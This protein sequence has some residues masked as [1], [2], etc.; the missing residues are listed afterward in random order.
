MSL[1]IVIINP[2]S[3]GGATRD[4]WPEIASDLATPL[5]ALRSVFTDGAGQGIELATWL[6]R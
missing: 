2:E 5:G 4:A 3:G 6:G 1:P